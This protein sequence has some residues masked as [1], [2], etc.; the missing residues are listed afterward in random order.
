MYAT[1]KPL[2]NLIP[3]F[4]LVSIAA[5]DFDGVTAGVGVVAGKDVIRGFGFMGPD[6]VTNRFSI[7]LG[8]TVS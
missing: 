8:G 4:R 1:D 5:E 2:N 7:P 3:Q 6:K